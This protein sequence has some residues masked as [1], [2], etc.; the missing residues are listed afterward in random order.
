[1][2]RGVGEASLFLA[3]EHVIHFDYFF[4]FF[5]LSVLLALNVDAEEGDGGK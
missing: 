2:E 1:M 3:S 4:F 5:V